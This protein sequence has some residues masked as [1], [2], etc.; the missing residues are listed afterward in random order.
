M[1]IDDIIHDYLSC[2][3]EFYQFF[4]DVQNA[5]NLTK[6][7]I[8]EIVQIKKSDYPDLR[9]DSLSE[10]IFSLFMFSNDQLDLSQEDKREIYDA[11]IEN[12]TF[13]N[14]YL[15]LRDMGNFVVD[16]LIKVD[17]NYYEKFKDIILTHNLDVNLFYISHS[18]WQH[19]L[20]DVL[21]S[22]ETNMA[23][24]VENDIYD[25]N[26]EGKSYVSCEV[27]KTITDWFTLFEEKNINIIEGLQEE[28]SEANSVISDFFTFNLSGYRNEQ[29]RKQT[30]N[31]IAFMQNLLNKNNLNFEDILVDESTEFMLASVNPYIFGSII[32][33][34]FKSELDYGKRLYHEGLIIKYNEYP[35]NFERLLA[36]NS[37]FDKD[38]L[39]K[40][41]EVA[42]ENK[43]KARI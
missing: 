41:L 30:E 28:Y 6:E 16:A 23:L 7:A 20:F 39:N 18:Q 21:K 25:L 32:T 27:L 29:G 14:I 3:T 34:V 11:F 4:S 2:K 8:L 42:A 13:E 24:R 35:E 12:H 1:D 19:D 22:G 37:K 31:Y 10:E 17:K 15:S 38:F 9:L 26:S 33:R 40:T 36:E 43:A 5:N